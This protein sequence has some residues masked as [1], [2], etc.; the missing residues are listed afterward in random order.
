MGVVWVLAWQ[1]RLGGLQAVNETDA[2]E[3]VQVSVD[4]QRCDFAF[5]SL[6]QQGDE[7]VGGKWPVAG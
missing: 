6:L 1:V 3:E 4:R 5:L 2:H 7:F